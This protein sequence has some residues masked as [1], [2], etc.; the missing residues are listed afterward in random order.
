MIY[1]TWKY[2]VIGAQQTQWKVIF[3]RT[4]NF[5]GITFYFS[6]SNFLAS[7]LYFYLTTE[8]HYL[9]QH[10]YE[11]RKPFW[12]S[13][14]KKD[15]GVVVAAARMY[16]YHLQHSIITVRLLTCLITLTHPPTFIILVMNNWSPLLVCLTLSLW[17]HL[18]VLFCQ[19]HRRLSSCDSPLPVLV[20]SSSSVHFPL[21]PSITPSFFYSCLKIDLFLSHHR[22]PFQL[23]DWLLRYVG[24]CF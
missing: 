2:R 5:L 18:P 24:Y 7:Y 19:P 15:D 21:S 17:N 9:L 22:L 8:N 12:V 13:V 16:A 6:L 3:T 14:I 1:D 10:W 20:T 4:C 23:H 11:N